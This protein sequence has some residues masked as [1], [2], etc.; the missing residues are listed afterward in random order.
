MQVDIEVSGDLA[1]VITLPK[2]IEFGI[3]AALT[4]TA[5]R[6]QTAV[7]EE[8]KKDLVVRTEWWRQDRKFGIKVKPATKSNKEAIIYTLADWLLELEGYHSG[9][10]TPDKHNGN[11]ANPDIEHTR[12]GLRNVV[13]RAEKAR[14]LLNNQKRTKAFKI[15]TKTGYQLILQRVGL[16]SFGNRLKSKTGGYLR[17]RGK[18][19]Q[20]ELVTKYLLIGKVKVPYKPVVTRPSIITFRLH[21]SSYLFQNLEKAIKS[22]KLKD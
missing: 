18:G 8:I 21:F 3:A 7:Q 13:R 2:Q 6:A 1:G 4:A 20:S 15:K 10:K 17:G 11:L 12:H 19:R 16:D 5:K 14:T 22:A 9:V